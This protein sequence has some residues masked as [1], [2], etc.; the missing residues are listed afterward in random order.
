MPLVYEVLGRKVSD[1]A[2][3]RRAATRTKEWCC[4]MPDSQV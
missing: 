4:T 3:A 1:Y 2:V